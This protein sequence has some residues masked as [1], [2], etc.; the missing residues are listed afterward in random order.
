MHSS[1]GK[2]ESDVFDDELSRRAVAAQQYPSLSKQRQE[3]LEE[4]FDELR[5]IQRQGRLWKPDDSKINEDIYEDAVQ[6][7]SLYICQKIE[8]YDPHRA[9]FLRWFNMLLPKKFYDL[10]YSKIGKNSA[11]RFFKIHEVENLLNSFVKPDKTPSLLEEVKECINVDAEGFLKKE[12]I[13]GHP[14]VNFQL[15]IQR[16]LAGDSWKDISLDVQINIF[17]LNKFYHRSLKKLAVHIK[18]YIQQ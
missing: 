5:R 11:S 4:L 18:K 16:R 12:H 14:H 3:A 13:K 15:L 10:A 8:K 7:L 17:H 2:G 9:S 1:D 6:E